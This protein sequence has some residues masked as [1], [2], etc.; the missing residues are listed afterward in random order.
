MR[1]HLRL[2]EISN[3]PHLFLFLTS[4]ITVSAGANSN[5]PR[6]AAAADETRVFEGLEK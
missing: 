1:F 4:I 3:I 6:R 5:R 2:P